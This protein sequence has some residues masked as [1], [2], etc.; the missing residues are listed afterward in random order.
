M[1]M[2]SEIKVITGCI[3]CGL[4]AITGLVMLYEAA[5]GWGWTL[6]IAALFWPY[7]SKE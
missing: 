6:L 5:E 2:D 3:V 4:S 1:K 7:K